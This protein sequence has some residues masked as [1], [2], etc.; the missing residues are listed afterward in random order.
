M[1][2]KKRNISKYERSG[3]VS[4]QEVKEMISLAKKIRSLAEDWIR[5]KHPYF[6]L[7]KS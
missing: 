1:F 5:K 7:K 6:K 2:R 3:F 4:E